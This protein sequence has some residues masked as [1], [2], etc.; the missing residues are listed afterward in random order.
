MPDI[1]LAWTYHYSK[2]T[3]STGNP[4][5]PAYLIMTRLQTFNG[6]NYKILI[7]AT[8]RSSW[9]V[10]L[11]IADLEMG[12]DHFYSKRYS[13]RTHFGLRAAW[14]NMEYN[15]SYKDFLDTGD[16]VNPG[17]TNYLQGYLRSK[18]DF[19]AVGPRMGFDSYLHIGWGFSLC[20]KLAAALLYGEY[21]SKSRFFVERE[22]VPFPFTETVT[23]VPFKHNSFSRL[24]AEVEMAIGLEWAYCFS[25]DYLLSFHIGWENQ[26]WWNQLEARLLTDY[27]PNG[28]LTYSGLDVGVRFDF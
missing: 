7:G 11:N 17:L 26:Y 23:N 9:R 25:G 14:I 6:G 8:G 18:S 28:D 22:S 12:Y 27:Q 4:N 2:A 13:L 21:D 15:A 5:V 1:L 19:W 24:R 3:D 20:G 10:H 16:N